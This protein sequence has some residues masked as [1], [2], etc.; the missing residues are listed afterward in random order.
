MNFLQSQAKEKRKPTIHLIR[1]IRDI[2]FCTGSQ[3]RLKFDFF[4]EVSAVSYCI[5]LS[6]TGRWKQSGRVSV[7]SLRVCKAD[8]IGAGN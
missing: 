7:L 6:P 5:N 8:T 4:L 3:K 1:T 2:I